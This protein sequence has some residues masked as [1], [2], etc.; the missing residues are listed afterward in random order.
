MMKL[1]N[2]P[3]RKIQSGEKTVELRLYDYKR[4]RLAISDEI[5][6]NNLENDGEE[7]AVRVK[8]LYRYGSFEDLF[9]E[10]SPEQ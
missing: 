9:S 6:F 10:I 5:I 4:R 1:K 2:E 3:F 7:L 8:A